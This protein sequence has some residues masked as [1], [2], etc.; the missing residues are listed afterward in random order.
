MSKKK[1]TH[2]GKR[3]GSG[4]KP[5]Y[6]EPTTTIAF[7][8]PISKVEKIKQLVKDFLLPKNKNPNQT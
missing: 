6:S 3:K 4:A 2:G 1:P 7:R 5:K 8:V